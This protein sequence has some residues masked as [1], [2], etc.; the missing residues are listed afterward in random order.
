MNLTG[1]LGVAFPA[2]VFFAAGILRVMGSRDPLN[3][4]LAAHSLIVGAAM[5]SRGPVR[6]E[7]RAAEQV[8]AWG[9]AILPMFF[10]SVDPVAPAWTQ[11]VAIA[12]VLLTIWA[13]LTLWRSFAVAPADR[14]LVTGGPYQLVRHPMY[15]GQMLTLLAILAGGADSLA[16]MSVL[17]S[18][19]GTVWRILREE[20]ILAS[21]PNYAA[22]VRW[23]LIPGVF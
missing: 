11:S 23:R 18:F 12:G 3:L 19:A 1:L 15:A 17:I 7:A 4:A 6:Q 14:G 16:W 21:Y 2:A 13:V 22:G 5:L 8:A 9:F 20:Q 10:V